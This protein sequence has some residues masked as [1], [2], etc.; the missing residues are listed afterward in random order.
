MYTLRLKA[1]TQMTRKC[2][3]PCRQCQLSSSRGKS[4]S[5]YFAVMSPMP[6]RLF[7]GIIVSSI[8]KEWDQCFISFFFIINVPLLPLWKNLYRLCISYNQEEVNNDAFVEVFETHH[9]QIKFTY[10]SVPVVNRKY[11]KNWQ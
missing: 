8:Q 1:H 11:D 3:D 10:A 5:W 2:L 7:G 6:S 4:I 9:H